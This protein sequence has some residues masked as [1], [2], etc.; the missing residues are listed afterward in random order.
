MT[1]TFNNATFNWIV[2]NL[3]L[4]LPLKA[5]K[6]LS[7]IQ[8]E[9]NVHCARPRNT[10]GTLVC[11]AVRCRAIR[12]CA[13]QQVW[14]PT[15]L[16]TYIRV[17]NKLCRPNFDHYWPPTYLPRVDI[18]WGIP[19][20]SYWE[21]LHIV[22]TS[23]TTYTYYLPGLVNVVCER[24]LICNYNWLSALRPLQIQKHPL[25]SESCSSIKYTKKNHRDLGK[26]VAL[27][28]YF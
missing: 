14:S 17:V 11:V 10:A 5:T 16:R 15:Y 6:W 22:D 1:L 4:F 19:L 27:V 2:Q 13:L 18:C 26:Y 12:R 25:W 28:T 8:N 20:V 21:S 3:F 7:I 9:W 24:P 23:S